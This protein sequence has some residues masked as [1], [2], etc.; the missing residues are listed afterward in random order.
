MLEY[1]RI[2]EPLIYPGRKVGR[3][4]IGVLR[5]LRMC[6]LQQWY[7]LADEALEDALYDSQAMR[8]FI[9]I[10]RAGDLSPRRQRLHRLGQTR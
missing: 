10:A 2:R 3:P 8:K 1:W 7:T 6:F 9:G 5:M 4:P